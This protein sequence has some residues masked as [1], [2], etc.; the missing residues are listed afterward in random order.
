MLRLMCPIAASLELTD[1]WNLKQQFTVN[2]NTSTPDYAIAGGGAVKVLLAAET[3]RGYAP[4]LAP[5]E[6]QR[7]H[8]DLDVYVFEPRTCRLT[9]FYPHEIYSGEEHG[10]FR[11]CKYRAAPEETA[12]FIELMTGYYFGFPPPCPTDAT[13]CNLEKQNVWTL[14]PEYLVASRFFSTQPLRAVDIT[15]VLGLRQRFDLNRQSIREIVSHSALGFLPPELV[16]R[17]L[18]TLDMTVCDLAIKTEL[19]ARFPFIG[20]LSLSEDQA[21]SWLDFAADDLDHERFLTAFSTASR[22]LHDHGI[23]HDADGLKSLTFLVYAL[24]GDMSEAT[25]KT[26]LKRVEEFPNYFTDREALYKLSLQ[27]LKRVIQLKKR[28]NKL[29]LQTYSAQLAQILVMQFITTD[30]HHVLLAELTLLEAKLKSCACWDEVRIQLVKLF[31]LIG[32]RT[33]PRSLR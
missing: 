2:A 18:D 24:D 29:R 13:V 9:L 16:V 33:L 26:V 12:F 11:R 3:I 10:R 14:T 21:R 6:S 17:S 20:S 7:Q 25:L 8:K 31:N 23:R 15:D 1:I 19:T 5:M 22:I 28:L 30:Y 27:F 32:Q 4:K